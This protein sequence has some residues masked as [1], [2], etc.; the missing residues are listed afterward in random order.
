LRD[1]EAARH[2]EMHDQGLA[3][4]QVGQ[5]ILG[6]AVKR[7]DRASSQARGEIF[8]EREAQVGPAL[9]D[10]NDARPHHR[11]RKPP[12][13]GFDFGQF[14]HLCSTRFG[15]GEPRM[16][17]RAKIWFPADAFGMRS[18]RCFATICR[19]TLT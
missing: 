2:A 17:S 19:A 1:E 4:G 9:L 8:R 7:R 3:R 18:I 12:P 15:T 13:H 6:P 16:M 11:G 5:E 10:R 14:G